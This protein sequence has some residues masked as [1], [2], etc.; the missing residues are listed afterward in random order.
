M[1]DWGVCG[2]GFEYGVSLLNELMGMHLWTYI[3]WLI[4]WAGPATGMSSFALETVMNKLFMGVL[5][6]S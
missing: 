6:V 2:S 3:I 4:R 5:V 1:R